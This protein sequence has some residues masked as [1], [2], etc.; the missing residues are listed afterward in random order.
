MDARFG[1]DIGT[2]ASHTR[3]RSSH[4]AVEQSNAREGVEMLVNER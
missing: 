4:W 1:K 2:L 3:M